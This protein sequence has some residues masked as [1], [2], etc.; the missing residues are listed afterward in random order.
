L[1]IVMVNVTF[2]LPEE[3]VERLRRFAKTRGKRGSI[4]EVVSAA[5][6]EHLRDVESLRQDEEFFAL[7]GSKEVA[8]AASLRGLAAKLQAKGIEPRSVLIR[9]S[10][11]AKPLARTGLRGRSE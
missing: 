3:T 6:S 1:R 8:R 9:S 7:E 2:S 4:S 11:P 5:I 10:L